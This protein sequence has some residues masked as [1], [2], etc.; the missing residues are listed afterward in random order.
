M[1]SRTDRVVVHVHEMATLKRVI[2][3]IRSISKN[4][5]IL[6][7][8]QPPEN[9][10]GKEM[11]K[12]M[13]A[14]VAVLK[15]H[16][17]LKTG[18]QE[19]WNQLEVKKKVARMKKTVDPKKPLWILVQN[20][21]DPDAIASAMA[22]QVLLGRNDKSAPIVTLKSVSRNENISMIEI[23]GTTVRKVR[24]TELNRA[25]QIA[26]V[27]VQPPYFKFALPNVVIVIDHHPVVEDYIVPYRDLQ[28][29]YG[30]TSTLLTEY[31]TASNI[32]IGQR[33]GTALYYGI[34]TDTLSL[35][36]AVS[37]ADF[38]S[39][40]ILWQKANHSQILHMERP[41]LRP[42]ELHIFARA[43]TEHTIERG[44]IFV[45]LGT[46]PKE[47]L[48]PRLADFVLQIGDTEFGIVWGIVNKDVIF[49]A[50]SITPLINAGEVMRSLFGRMGSAGGHRTMAR[51]TMPLAV[52]KKELKAGTFKKIS[53]IVKKRVLR[54]IAAQKL[55][56]QKNGHRV[57]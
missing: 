3:R 49:S 11:E 20:D 40:T 56:M 33:L 4:V 39:F 23:I 31:L 13:D 19:K 53:E 46:V 7:F 5:P 26:M 12:L 6:L 8:D 57:R 24:V 45:G 42:Q 52:L 25:P 54:T 37:N 2:K 10:Q 21:P 29:N 14:G 17:F 41:R 1:L 55:A 44:A 15:V 51:A 28:V 9:M 16:D 32:K 30:A 47:D 48:V 22:L 50:R 27:D 34:K 36:R 35:G 38:N 43:L 18:A